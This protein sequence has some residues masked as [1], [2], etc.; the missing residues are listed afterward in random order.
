MF[1][2]TSLSSPLRIRSS[3]TET[4]NSSPQQLRMTGILMYIQVPLSK[5]N[6]L[7]SEP[8]PLHLRSLGSDFLGSPPRDHLIVICRAFEAAVFGTVSDSTPWS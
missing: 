3:S 5:G 2:L 8:R 6:A 1:L 4:R 7:R